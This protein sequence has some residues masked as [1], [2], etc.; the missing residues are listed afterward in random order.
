MARH[1][2]A[3]EDLHRVA[4]D[5]LRIGECVR[6]GVW[7][8]AIQRCQ[9]AYSLTLPGLTGQTGY[10]VNGDALKYSQF[11]AISPTDEG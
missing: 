5:V 7:G 2:L 4:K 9:V 3:N 6:V 10:R 11:G 8:V 1:R